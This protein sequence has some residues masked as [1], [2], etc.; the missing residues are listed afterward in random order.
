MTRETITRSHL[1]SVLLQSADI[2]RSKMDAPEFKQ[3]IFG[4][5]PIKRLCDEFDRKREQLRT[6]DFAHV[7]EAALLKELLED[8]TSI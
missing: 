2:R 3:F 8:K 6:K 1:D 7:T 5:L 4:M